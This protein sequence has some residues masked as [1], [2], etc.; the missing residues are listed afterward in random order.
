MKREPWTI[1]VWEIIRMRSIIATGILGMLLLTSC[2]TT[3]TRLDAVWK[4]EK[5]EGFAPK[6][7]LV[8]AASDREG[9]RRLYEDKFVDALKN[10]NVW[11]LGSADRLPGSDQL[12]REA[13]RGIVNEESIDAVLVTHLL[14]VD[15]AKTYHPP[16]TVQVPVRMGGY[17]GHYAT[18]YQFATTEGYYTDDVSVF[19]E[20][21][22][23]DVETK[24]LAWSANSETFNHEKAEDSMDSAIEELVLG[25]SES[26][27]VR[28]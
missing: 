18:A 8:I 6:R 26:N 27:L 21:K 7:I 19:L 1:L 24:E 12:D 22:L 3:N 9:A 10:S 15:R 23:Y 28:Q 5:L 4:N 16:T 17:Y 20:T 13:I 2:A 25:L 11:A 14:K